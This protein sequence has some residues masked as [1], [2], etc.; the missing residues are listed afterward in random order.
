[1]YSAYQ[2]R[3][4]GSMLGHGPAMSFLRSVAGSGTLALRQ[5]AFP[6]APL[7]SALRGWVMLPGK[8]QRSGIMLPKSVQYDMFVEP[9]ASTMFHHVCCGVHFQRF[10]E[11][12]LHDPLLRSLSEACVKRAYHGASHT[13]ALRA[14][15]QGTQQPGP[16]H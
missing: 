1:M 10:F 4:H 2:R 12:N 11:V 7:D 14:S 8:C 9:C 5:S 16:L 6:P 3:V 15:R 13:S